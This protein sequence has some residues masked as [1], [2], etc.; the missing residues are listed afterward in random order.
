MSIRLFAICQ[1]QEE[2][3]DQVGRQQRCDLRGVVGG[4]NLNDVERHKVETAKPAHKP[5][6][7]ATCEARD[8]RR[9]G[10]RG[11]GGID[12]VDV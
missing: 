6:D 5:H 3:V 1:D 10:A 2:L 11:E 9:A 8:L 12:A 4:S 7:L